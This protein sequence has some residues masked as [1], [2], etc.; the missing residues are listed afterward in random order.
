MKASEIRKEAFEILKSNLIKST[1]IILIYLLFA[2][3]MRCLQAFL[4]TGTII[5]Q[6]FSLVL[7]IINIPLSFGLVVVFSKL[8]NNETI[9][10]FD[11]LKEGFSK[12]TKSF[13]IFMYTFLNLWIP[14]LFMIIVFYALIL[15]ASNSLANFSNNHILTV[16]FN[17]FNNDIRLLL[18]FLILLFV[19]ILVYLF[20]KYLLYVLSYNICYNNPDLTSKECILKSKEIMKGNRI[21]YCILYVS[22]LGWYLAFAIVCSII[23]LLATAILGSTLGIFFTY[24]LMI[25]GI[26]FLLSYIK[27]S[28]I[29]FYEKVAN[30]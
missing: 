9:G 17:L 16:V 21:K 1:C 4:G 12:F 20:I 22:F 30:I 5:S 26:S 23:S 15:F 6:I 11:F 13:K 8:K 10:I 28:T 27:I 7:L 29:C 25:I 24:L 14:I 2:F 3:A 18:I 19:I